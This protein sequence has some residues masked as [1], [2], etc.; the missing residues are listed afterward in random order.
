MHFPGSRLRRT[1]SVIL[2]CEARTFLIIIPFGAILRDCS[3]RSALIQFSLDVSSDFNVSQP[4]RYS[5]GKLFFIIVGLKL[6]GAPID[7]ERI[8]KGLTI[9]IYIVF[10]I[11]VEI[12]MR[13]LTALRFVGAFIDVSGIFYLRRRIFMGC[14]LSSRSRTDPPLQMRC[15]G[16]D[17]R[18]FHRKYSGSWCILCRNCPEE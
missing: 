18:F 17:R 14:R 15:A 2:P 11:H 12:K 16:T 4:C 6:R 8:G 10:I 1:L 9:E 7:Q 5:G 13:N 3:V